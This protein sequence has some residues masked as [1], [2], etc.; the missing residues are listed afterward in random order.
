MLQRDPICT[1]SCMCHMATWAEQMV[2][3]ALSTWQHTHH[4][5]ALASVHNS[6]YVNVC[7]YMLTLIVLHVHTTRPR[8]TFA[9]VFCLSSCLQMDTCDDAEEPAPQGAQH[10]TANT[11]QA[12]QACS[13]GPCTLLSAPHSSRPSSGTSPLFSLPF[14]PLSWPPCCRDDAEDAAQG[15]LQLLQARQTQ[16]ALALGASLESLNGL[17]AALQSAG[18]GGADPWETLAFYQ[19]GRGSVQGFMHPLLQQYYAPHLAAAATGRAGAGLAALGLTG[20]DDGLPESAS[21]TPQ[22]SVALCA[23]YIYLQ[24]VNTW[25]GVQVSQQIPGFPTHFLPVVNNFVLQNT[26]QVLPVVT[27]PVSHLCC[28]TSRPAAESWASCHAECVDHGRILSAARVLAP[29]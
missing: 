8:C 15:L 26:E 16:G 4:G 23:L 19:Q 9:T 5:P 22:T 20:G 3:V 13:N 2:I 1:R 6:R 25:S 12:C 21:G 11:S 18:V 7:S 28:G 14:C 29:Q 24:R 10:L 27:V 17:S